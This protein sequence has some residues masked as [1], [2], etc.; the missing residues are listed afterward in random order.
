MTITQ[1]ARAAIYLRSRK[2]RSDVSI[3]TQRRQLQQL[4]TERGYTIVAEFSDVVE[5]GKDELRDR[6][7][8]LLGAVRTKRRGWDTL[9]ILD[10]SRLA[11]RR[12]ISLVFEEV[13]AR[14]H[15]VRVVYK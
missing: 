3:D 2:D 9:L 1:I 4:A 13:E 5:S 11:R 14:K 15:G 6:F 12:H 10:T 8:K 7:Q